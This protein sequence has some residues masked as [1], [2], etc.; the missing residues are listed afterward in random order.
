[1]VMKASE[2]GLRFGKVDVD[3]LH[4]RVYADASFATN[5]DL[6]SQLGYVVLLC[7]E[8]DRCHLLD[9]TSR[10]SK[11]VVRS[12]MGGE[13]YDF[14]DAFDLEFVMRSDLEKMMGVSIA[15]NMMTD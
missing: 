13:V 9:Y 6:S 1:M 10:K 7:D 5:E 14:M 4:L 8:T 12:I 15:I 3:S 11:R 2:C